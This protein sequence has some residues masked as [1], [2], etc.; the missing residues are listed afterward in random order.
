ML[1][2]M[3]VELAA[4][5][6]CWGTSSYGPPS[7]FTSGPCEH[8]TR[9][10]TSA[11]NSTRRTPCAAPQPTYDKHESPCVNAGTRQESTPQKPTLNIHITCGPRRIRRS[12][13]ARRSVALAEWQRKAAS[14]FLP[15]VLVRISPCAC[16][17]PGNGLLAVAFARA[18][19]HTTEL[20]FTTAF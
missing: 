6:R 13:V 15:C 12:R 10:C 9:K 1:A 8:K 19:P 17:F 11:L 3:W 5:R 14:V 16:S 4:A 20:H 7:C 18:Y 2:R